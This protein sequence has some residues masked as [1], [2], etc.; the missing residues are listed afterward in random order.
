MDNEF[1]ARQKPTKT[2]VCHQALHLLLVRKQSPI[3][4]EERRYAILHFANFRLQWMHNGQLVL[5][6]KIGGFLHICMLYLPS[7]TIIYKCIDNAIGISTL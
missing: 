2:Y 5:F 7:L 3:D 6:I 4:V 1:A